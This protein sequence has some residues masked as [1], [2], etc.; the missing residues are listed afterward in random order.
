MPE[1][2]FF[3]PGWNRRP[4][5]GI[6]HGFEI[7]EMLI[8][9][10]LL[11]FFLRHDFASLLKQ[12]R[13]HVVRAMRRSPIAVALVQRIGLGCGLACE[14]GPLGTA[15]PADGYIDRPQF[16]AKTVQKNES[17]ATSVFVGPLSPGTSVFAT[18]TEHGVG[19]A[20]LV[21]WCH[22]HLSLSM[23]IAPTG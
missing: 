11:T 10:S 5:G 19:L 1:F 17:P 21:E 3:G 9:R 2:F 22:E 18:R 8:V 15:A 20:G 4:R 12:H 6:Y 13:P 7:A 16:R 14:S 23:T